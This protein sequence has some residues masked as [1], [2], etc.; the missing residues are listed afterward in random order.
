[1]RWVWWCFGIAYPE[2]FLCVLWDMIDENEDWSIEEELVAILDVYGSW[3]G[4]RFDRR[5]R[6]AL[7]NYQRLAERV[8]EKRK[9]PKP[10]DDKFGFSISLCFGILA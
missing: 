6:S 5:Y 2:F 8:K 4:G 7:L 9:K 10:I 1:M 3:N